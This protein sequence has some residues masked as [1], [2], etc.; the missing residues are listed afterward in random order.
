MRTLTVE[1]SW[2]DMATSLSFHSMCIKNVVARLYNQCCRFLL[3]YRPQVSFFLELF[4]EAAL[5]EMDFVRQ[6]EVSPVTIKCL[7][8]GSAWPRPGS[9]WFHILT[10]SDYP[11]GPWNW[12]IR[13]L[14]IFVMP[15]CYFS[16]QHC[17]QRDGANPT[18]NQMKLFFTKT[19]VVFRTVAFATFFRGGLFPGS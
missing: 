15:R 13:I 4:E 11:R 18:A 10:K 5:R 8:N 6:E 12:S 9:W 17:Q 2:Q 19:C 3:S 7:S 1:T 14:K 16:E